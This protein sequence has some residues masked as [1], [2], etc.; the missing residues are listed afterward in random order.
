MQVLIKIP[1]SVPNGKEAGFA[2]TL[3]N[4][5]DTFFRDLLSAK[6]MQLLETFQTQNNVSSEQLVAMRHALEAEINLIEQACKTRTIE[7]VEDNGVS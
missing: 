3:Q 2:E 5:N 6:R 1:L 7:L 4:L